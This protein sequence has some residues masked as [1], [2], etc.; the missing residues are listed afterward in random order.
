MALMDEQSAFEETMVKNEKQL[1][2]FT[3]CSLP[4]GAN[5]SIERFEDIA[6]EIKNVESKFT[7]EYFE[8]DPNFEVPTPTVENYNNTLD[9]DWYFVPKINIMNPYETTICL[10]WTPQKEHRPEKQ[11]RVCTSLSQSKTQIGYR[12]DSFFLYF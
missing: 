11:I 5:K 9:S 4:Y 2:S 7:I 12:T 1:P 8:Y 6:S 10:I 3:L